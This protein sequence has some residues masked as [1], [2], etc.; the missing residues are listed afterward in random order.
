MAYTATDR[1]Q[2]RYLV[3]S[4][5]NPLPTYERLFGIMGRAHAGIEVHGS[6]IRCT[7]QGVDSLRTAVALTPGAKT[8]RVTS[9][10][11]KAKEL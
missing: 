4:G 6:V 8:I 3:F 9:S 5:P 2:Q 1:E 7:A 11:T 10:I